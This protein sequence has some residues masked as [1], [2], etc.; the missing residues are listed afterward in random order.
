MYPFTAD[1]RLRESPLHGLQS[2]G[3]LLGLLLLVVLLRMIGRCRRTWLLLGRS[4]VSILLLGIRR[5]HH[6]LRLIR[7]RSRQR[8]L[9]RHIRSSLLLWLLNSL[10]L[11][12][13]RS[14]ARRRVDR[15]S[16]RSRWSRVPRVSTSMLKALMLTASEQCK[17]D[18][19]MI[20]GVLIMISCQ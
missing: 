5:W 19:T 13:D 3:H 11:R 16:C 12:D 9:L 18:R 10:C 6:R 17:S 1:T 7:R 8:V 20:S 14:G 2:V 15:W 4:I